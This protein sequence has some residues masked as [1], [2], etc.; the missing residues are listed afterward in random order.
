MQVSRTGWYP[1]LFDREI[2]VM[3]DMLNAEIP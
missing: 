2:K 3:F 1:Q